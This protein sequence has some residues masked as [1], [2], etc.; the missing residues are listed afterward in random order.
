VSP[1]IAALVA[2]LLAFRDARD[3]KQFHTLKNLVSALS[4]EAAELLELTQWKTS[5][6]LEAALD[7]RDLKLAF[8]KEIA[9]IFVYLL[10]TCE[11]LNI[12]PLVAVREKL[13]ENEIKYPV[14]KSRGSAKK[15]SEF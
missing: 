10:L 2:Q 3:W 14:E 7:D 1:D 5:E 9:D 6:E 13:I 8:A 12:D 11:K 15:Y 4:V